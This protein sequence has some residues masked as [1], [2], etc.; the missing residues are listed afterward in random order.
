MVAAH[1]GT[2]ARTC[3]EDKDIKH[4]DLVTKSGGV[5]VPL[6]AES[7]GVWSPFARKTLKEIASRTA[8]KSGLGVSPP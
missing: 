5:S 4:L 7:L 1:S 2:G 8:V 3:E 6:V